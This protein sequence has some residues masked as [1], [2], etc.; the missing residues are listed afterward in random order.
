MSDQYA[1]TSTACIL[2]TASYFQ[3]RIKVWFK[4]ARQ[5]EVYSSLQNGNFEES[6]D[7]DTTVCLMKADRAGHFDACQWVAPAS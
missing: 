6:I 1:Y 2:A 5:P 4:G 7:P 3:F